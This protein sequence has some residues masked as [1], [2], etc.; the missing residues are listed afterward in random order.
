MTNQ[1]DAF[2][3]KLQTQFIGKE[4]ET[5]WEERDKTLQEWQNLIKTC[6]P[7]AENVEIVV[8]AVNRMM[9]SL[10]TTLALT[11]L[12]TVQVMAAELELDDDVLEKL[13][14]NLLK[15]TAT[16][17]RIVVN[18]AAETVI[19]VIN[20]CTLNYRHV[21]MIA[22]KLSEKNAAFRASLASF[23]HLVLKKG[24]T[25]PTF[26]TH[27]LDLIETGLRKTVTDANPSAREHSKQ[28]IFLLRAHWPDRLSAWQDT[29]DLTTRKATDKILETP[30][31]TSRPSLKEL[32]KAKK[33]IQPPPLEFAIE[34]TESLEKAFEA[35]SLESPAEPDSAATL[36]ETTLAQQWTEWLVNGK[37][38]AHLAAYDNLESE[39]KRQVLQLAQEH[40][41][42]LLG[43]AIVLHSS[44]LEDVGLRQI[45]RQ[46]LG[47]IVTDVQAQLETLLGHVRGA[48]LA[49]CIELISAPSPQQ[50]S[51]INDALWD[52]SIEV[53]RQATLWC[54]RSVKHGNNVWKMLD[55][56]TVRHKRRLIEQYL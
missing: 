52:T 15:V 33:S 40:P 47:M 2:C 25:Q 9:H 37:V 13:L 17:K 44:T 54:V 3:H 21:D 49:R 45:A 50:A 36:Q 11:S 14:E 32:M 4:G 34:P 55:E 48:T 29:L 43:I 28:M 30:V 31:L 5:T 41:H 7:S 35:A 38:G 20:S 24:A 22:S 53:R 12:V 10:R 46:H 18:A 27:L 42:S 16:T 56:K 6:K 51:F 8:E 1:M 26:D 19:S 39:E 23:L